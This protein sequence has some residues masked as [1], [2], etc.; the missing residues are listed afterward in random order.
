MAEDQKIIRLYHY[1]PAKYAEEFLRKDEIKLCDLTKSNDLCEFS[2]RI[3]INSAMAANIT[4][5]ELIVANQSE[6]IVNSFR[7][8][9]PAIV[10][11]FSTRISSSAVWGHYADKNEG[12]CLVFDLPICDIEK[13]KGVMIGNLKGSSETLFQRVHYTGKR[14][15]LDATECVNLDESVYHDLCA[16]TSYKSEDWKYEKECR[17]VFYQTKES[18]SLCAKNGM[19]FAKGLRQ[20]LSGIVL[21]PKCPLSNIYFKA[22][23]QEIKEEDNFNEVYEKLIVFGG[24]E[25]ARLDEVELRI[26]SN[27]YSDTDFDEMINYQN[28]E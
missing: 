15:E 7:G 27:H 21:G 12:V 14:F 13:H 20:Y 25:R 22:I 11:S 1:M 4:N 9:C 24:V 10:L 18:K 19:F 3:V 2:P 8:K 6:S 16:A 26:K 28:K 5:R 17:L 23:A